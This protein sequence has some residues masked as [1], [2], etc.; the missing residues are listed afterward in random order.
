MKTV[1]VFAGQGAQTVGMGRELYD[2]SAAARKVFEE[3]DSVLDWSVSDVCFN[4]PDEKLTASKYCQSAIYTVS[5]AC[6]AAFRERIS[7]IQPVAAAGLSLGEYSALACA[8][9]LR[10]A[11]GLRLVAR[12]GELMDKACRE[13]PGGMT[14]I[15]GL[16]PEIIADVCAAHD[17]DVANYNSPGQIVI[18]GVKERVDAAAAELKSKGARRIVPLNVA[19]GFHCRLMKQA[20]EALAPVLAATDFAVPSIPVAQNFSG[21]LASDPAEIRK[22]LECQVAGSVRWET[23]VRTMVSELGAERFIEFG[24][25]AVVSGL[26]RKI[27][28]SLTTG[29]VSS[30]AD[31]ENFV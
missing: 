24:P 14:C 9:S 19:G 23:C 30:P 21:A 1:F 20:G 31:I 13:N 11:D 4:G 8:G 10:F 17:I 16:A 25:G 12:R 2:A 7:G 26:V 15:L 3:A 6:L 22:N 5:M 27:D 28:P 29:N 18:S